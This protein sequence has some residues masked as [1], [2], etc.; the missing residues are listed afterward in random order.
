M[1]V[2]KTMITGLR[3]DKQCTLNKKFGR[4]LFIGVVFIATVLT[5]SVATFGEIQDKEPVVTTKEAAIRLADEKTASL[6]PILSVP[7]LN[8]KVKIIDRKFC[9]V[10][11]TNEDKLVYQYRVDPAQHVIFPIHTVGPRLLPSLYCLD[12]K[13]NLYVFSYSNNSDDG[14]LRGR[15]MRIESPFVVR[16]V[17][18][19]E[20]SIEYPLEWRNTVARVFTNLYFRDGSK[21]LSDETIKRLKSITVETDVN[22]PEV[23]RKDLLK[24][25]TQVVE[26]LNARLLSWTD[27]LYEATNGRKERVFAKILLR[28]Q[29]LALANEVRVLQK[30]KQSDERYR[31]K[32]YL[33]N[34]LLM[35]RLIEYDDG[36]ESDGAADYGAYFDSKI[37][38]DILAR[39]KPS[40][41]SAPE[42][43]NLERQVFEALK[44]CSSPT[45]S[46]D[47]A[48]LE[49]RSDGRLVFS[50][51]STVYGS[52]TDL[53]L[54]KLIL[55][56]ET[57]HVIQVG[58]EKQS[59]D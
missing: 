22:D 17:L 41:V 59:S 13:G 36:F 47:R 24:L 38:W 5:S 8:L 3:V 53:I 48:T 40:Y 28:P 33:L 30:Q 46:T 10:D 4:F 43:T 20:E 37:S 50:V 35:D 52:P 9:L 42:I 12:D 51:S 11:K 44:D 32:L 58:S 27:S 56:A 19:K 57:G 23:E 26:L 2:R 15:V 54:T 55:K 14:I 45:R 16:S 49:C 34:R 29:E 7:I 1:A 25:C 31:G 39:K 6:F 18:F 21:P